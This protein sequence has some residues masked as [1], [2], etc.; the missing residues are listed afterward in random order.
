MKTLFINRHAKSSWKEEGLRDFDR[1]LNKRGLRDAPFMANVFASRER[2]V[3]A[4]VSSPANRAHTTAKYFAE[5]LGWPHEK[6]VL[7]EAIYAAGLPTLINL[8]GG[9]TDDWNQV[10]MFGHNPGFSYLVE[11]LC[12]EYF[13]MPTCG[14]AKITFETDEW[15]KAI[16]MIGRAEYL[17]FPKNHMNE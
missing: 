14:I 11:E 13:A 8:V 16:G 4:I 17:D 7:E 12:G 9:F 10:I 5:A 6:I 1:P 3:D 15:S 2:A